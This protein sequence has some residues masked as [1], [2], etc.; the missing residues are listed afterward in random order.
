MKSTKKTQQRAEKSNI[1]FRAKFA[2]ETLVTPVMFNPSGDDIKKIKSLPEDM[3]ITDP[4]YKRTLKM[5]E[6][7]E[8]VEK[9]Y[10][11]LSL[12]CS[13]NPNAILKSKAYPQS[14]FVN[15]DILVSPEQVKGRDKLDD[16]KNPIVGTAKYQVI[17]DHN[18]SG[19]V[20]IKKKQSVKDAV[21]EAIDSSDYNK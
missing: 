18:Q 21:Q 8:K 16:N 20:L 4:T 11:V 12:L 3:T 14:M 10:S 1:N 7:G 5:Y 13:F 17:D 6:D 15:Y 2:G 19:W 9:E